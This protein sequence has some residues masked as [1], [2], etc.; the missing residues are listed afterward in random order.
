MIINSATLHTHN[1][2][3]DK[4]TIRLMTKAFKQFG[5]TIELRY[6]PDRRSIVEANNGVVDGEFVRIA[7]ITDK[8][9]NIQMC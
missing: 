1:D 9:P 2:S 5:I 3:Q 4:T 8:Y 6:R 7:S